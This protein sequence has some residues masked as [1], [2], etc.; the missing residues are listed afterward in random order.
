M[1]KI[2]F[3]GLGKLGLGVAL[4]IESRGH[5]VIGYDISPKTVK[6]IEKREWPHYEEGLPELLAK[7]KLQIKSF[8]D[9][10]L[11]SDI[12]F[13]PIQ[14]PHDPEYEGVTLIPDLRKDF[15][16]SYL[17]KAIEQIASLAIQ[18]DK[19]VTLAVI[20]TCLPETFKDLIF[21]IIN[22][23]ISY[24][25][26]P[27]FIA[28]GTTINDYLNPE[29]NLIGVADTE[30]AD[31]LEEFYKTINDAPCLK[32]DIT[33]AEA[34]KVSYNTFITMKT[35]IGNL[36]GEVAHKTGANFED[37][38]KAWSLS[39]KRLISMKYLKSGV[40]DGGGCHPRDNIALSYLSDK[41]GM[42]HNVWDDLMYAR[43]NH[44]AWLGMSA[45]D[46]ALQHELPIVI[47]GRAFKPE[48]NI[49]TGSP[50]LLLYNIVKEF[51]V[52]VECV[53]DKND[54]KPAVYVMGTAHER[55]KDIVFP[56]NSIVVDPFGI[57]KDQE[58]VMVIRIGRP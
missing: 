19:H 45:V 12:V 32:T 44:M 3:I 13:V 38:Y 8:E 54:M 31:K 27:Q 1:S 18:H 16:Y 15:D 26:T 7:T 48:T 11:E 24:V 25:Y 43:Q 47:L 23:H 17:L 35:V 33:T 30:A 9:V 29:F 52:P 49:E 4:A 50:A 41:I 37:I 57:I 53:E 55:Y 46:L 10:V 39:T 14:T 40:G 6:A 56:P 51:K 28:M 21:P 58:G 42:S 34:I 22:S 20:S 2:G 36:W 5:E